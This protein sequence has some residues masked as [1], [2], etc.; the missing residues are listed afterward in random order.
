MR[1]H[2]QTSVA[3][4]ALLGIGWLLGNQTSTNGQIPNVLNI[5]Q[6]EYKADG[7]NVA[8]ANALGKDGWELV[9]VHVR[10]M[11]ENVPCISVVCNQPIPR[12][13]EHMLRKLR[14]AWS[15]VFGV[16][17]LLPSAAAACARISRC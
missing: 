5:N 6:W 9:G 8:S 7:F 1:S 4:V 15:A 12:R 10:P 16:M 17:C 11:E 13:N 2:L 14:I 3:F